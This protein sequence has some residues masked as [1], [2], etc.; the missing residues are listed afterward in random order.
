MRILPG[1][2]VLYKHITK[3]FLLT[4]DVHH[5]KIQLEV[6]VAL[7]G[8]QPSAVWGC[9]EMGFSSPGGDAICPEGFS[10]QICLTKLA[11]MLGLGG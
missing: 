10:L 4:F 5:E 6:W 11:H 8:L 7:S 9:L 2:Y 1:Y 3:G